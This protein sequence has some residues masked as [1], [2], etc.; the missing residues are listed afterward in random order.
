[1]LNPQTTDLPISG[2]L[3]RLS[4]LRQLGRAELSFLVALSAIAGHLFS[5]IKLGGNALLVGLG[6]GLLAM[7]CSALNQ[8]QEQDLDARMERTRQRPL[9]SGAL[10]E[11]GALLLALTGIGGGL[12]L[13]SMLPNWL[14]LLLG[15]LATIWYN[16][17]YTPLKQRTPFAAFPGA[18]CGTLPPLIGWAASGEPIFSPPALILAGTLFLWQI[19]HTWLL[20]CRHRLDLQRSGLPD[21]F[22]AIPIKRLL[23]I[24]LC[25]LVALAT[26][27]FLFPLFGMIENAWLADG[28]LVL[29]AAL[30][31]AVGRSLTNIGRLFHLVNL[32]MALL[33]FTLICD[34]LT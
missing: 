33:L 25:W 21:L 11:I 10:T 19:P 30:M 2:L 3:Q 29:L 12:L 6:V 27:Y 14:P 31:I 16:G 32:S 9:P 18:V 1:M 7:G 17:I 15:I 20:L 4:L 5:G 24:N 13:L 8:W 22:E 28:F 26:C 23:Q 34:N